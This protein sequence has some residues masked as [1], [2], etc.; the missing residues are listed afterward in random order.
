M[1]T[2]Q[3]LKTFLR[4]RI[5]APLGMKDTSFIHKSYDGTQVVNY[6]QWQSRAAFEAAT[7]NPAARPHMAAAAIAE[8]NPILCEVVDSISVSA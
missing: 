3:P 4:E 7:Q 8:F 1:A 2:G 6:A 5:F